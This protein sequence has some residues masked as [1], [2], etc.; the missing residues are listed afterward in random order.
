MSS[1]AR[2]DLII[3]EPALC[4]A[5]NADESHIFNGFANDIVNITQLQEVVLILT[6][7]VLRCIDNSR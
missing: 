7:N 6:E 3:S 5:K 2:N 1:L 4:Q